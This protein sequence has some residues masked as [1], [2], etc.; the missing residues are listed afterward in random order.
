MVGQTGIQKFENVAGPLGQVLPFSIG[1]EA[2]DLEDETDRLIAAASVEVQAAVAAVAAV[3]VVESWD[4]E[5]P[6]IENW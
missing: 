4:Q 3:V 1:F 2:A 6:S 5:S